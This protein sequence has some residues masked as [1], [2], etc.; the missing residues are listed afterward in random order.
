MNMSLGLR[1]NLAPG[2][3]NEFEEALNMGLGEAPRTSDFGINRREK[4]LKDQLSKSPG[5]GISP[6]LIAAAPGEVMSM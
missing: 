4:A 1:S 6:V 3:L 2:I 5:P